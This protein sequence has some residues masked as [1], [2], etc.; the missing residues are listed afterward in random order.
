MVLANPLAPTMEREL[1]PGFMARQ[2]RIADKPQMRCKTRLGYCLG[3]TS[4]AAGNTT[5]LGVGVRTLKG[6]EMNLHLS[7][8]PCLNSSGDAFHRAEKRQTQSMK[9][10]PQNT[11]KYC[12]CP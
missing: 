10:M 9:N 6:E 8:L 2:G 7:F 12:H 5:G 11:C 3:K 4:D 1:L